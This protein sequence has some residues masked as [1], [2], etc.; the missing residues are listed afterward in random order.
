MGAGIVA[1]YCGPFYFVCLGIVAA[2][3]ATA[4]GRIG[5]VN[6]GFS[7]VSEKDAHELDESLSR[8]D[9]ELELHQELLARLQNQLPTTVLAPPESADVQVVV[10]LD[11]IDFVQRSGSNIRLEATGLMIL[12]WSSGDAS[13]SSAPLEFSTRTDDRDIDA[14]LANDG[15][16][17]GESIDDCIAKLADAMTTKLNLIHSSPHAESVNQAR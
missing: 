15:V 13:V 3:S 17:L 10:H 4:A 2:A 9:G 16:Q 11:R 5:G 8:L 1:L 7:G 14:W 12:G 6:Y